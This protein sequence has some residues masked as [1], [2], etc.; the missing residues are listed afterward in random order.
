[1]KKLLFIS[2]AL[3]IA[4][5]LFESCANPSNP[6]GGE[7]DTIPPT[8]IHSIPVAGSTQFNET[9][10]LLEF[11]EY[12]NADK[13]KQ[14]LIITPKTDVKFKHL[15]KK[16]QLQIKFEQPFP[17]TTTFSLNFFDGVTD[18]TE[19]NPSENLV[20]AF[21]TGTFI[22]SLSVKGQVMELMTQDKTKDFLVGLY[23]LSDSLDFLLDA[24]MYF[25]TTN[26]SGEFKMSYIKAGLYKLLAYQDENKNLIL[27]PETEPHGFVS[28]TLNLRNDTLSI[29]IYTLLQNV[30]P[31]KIIN[32]RP[33]G[34]YHE[35]K[36]S[37]QVESYEFQPDTIPNILVGDNKDVL[38]LY[39]P[40][41]T[42]FGDSIEF[43]ITASD[44]LNN[45]ITDT[46]KVVFTKSNRKANKFTSNVKY[47]DKSLVD[48]PS[49]ILNFSKPIR[50]FDSTLLS[51][52]VDSTFNYKPEIISTFWNHNRTALKLTTYVNKDSLYYWYEQAL[53][54]DTAD[55]DTLQA[56]KPST[57][58]S[59]TNSPMLFFLEKAAF[60]SIENDSSE[61][62]TVEHQSRPK[63]EFGL[64][65][66][67]IITDK[68]SFWIQFLNKQDKVV[69]EKAND[70]KPTF[71]VAP[72]TYNIRILIDSNQDGKWSYG[73]LIHN[74]EP[75]QVFLYPEEI[76]VRENWTYEDILISF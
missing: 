43:H 60:I 76:V 26:D 33:I 62:L 41:Q 16:N 30:K 8:L 17:D 55:A 3:I 47:P 38:R 45:T 34:P 56:N 19:K 15:I 13:L 36:F 22:D 9:E 48:N 39:N 20:I 61:L 4:D 18:I 27:D 51:Y 40:T 29:T 21:S 12:I 75:E 5:L 25:T 70:S 63:E 42:S 44:S 28:D 7:K 35:I 14:N 68:K 73:N 66:F 72:G 37:K 52:R 31:I 71:K 49:Y 50:S 69:Y 74:E 65:T 2:L 11:S 53:P 67:N 32:N 59:S 46:L 64:L 54:K 10:I 23:P 57:S 6:T 58:K 24:P 1:M